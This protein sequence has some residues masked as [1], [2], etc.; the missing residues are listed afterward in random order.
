VDIHVSPTSISPSHELIPLCCL[1][2]TLITATF[3]QRRF[4]STPVIQIPM[5]LGNQLI[6]DIEQRN[7]C[8]VYWVGLFS[9]G[10]F[11]TFLHFGGYEFQ[12]YVQLGWWDVLTHFVSGIG[13][14]GILLVGLRNTISPQAPLS[15]VFIA[16]LSI[17]AGFEVYEYIFRS[18]WHSWTPVYYAQDTAED[19]L[20]A[21]TGGVIFQY[22]FRTSSGRNSDS[23]VPV[24]AQSAD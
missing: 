24:K 12:W 20:M 19:L 1:A 17:G 4:L 18:F 21:C 2:L 11:V 15:W 22:Y 13:V 6:A 23:N 7:S 9:W 5:S 16:L 8:V 14:A 3:A 10:G